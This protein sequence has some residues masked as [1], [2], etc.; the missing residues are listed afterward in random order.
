M[1]E[2]DV[3]SNGALWRG[4]FKKYL[5]E[6]Q[7]WRTHA[8]FGDDPAMYQ[9]QFETLYKR[10]CQICRHV[11]VDKT[12]KDIKA[13]GDIVPGS[14]GN[15]LV[16]LLWHARYPRLWIAPFCQERTHSSFSGLCAVVAGFH[17][18]ASGLL[19]SF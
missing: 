12:K 16:N 6:A 10:L 9:Q 8:L 11:G 14:F 2:E 7:H 15:D 4:P 19:W 18:D 5:P 13:K 3:V 1:C 17:P